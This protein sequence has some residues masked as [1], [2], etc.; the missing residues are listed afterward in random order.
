[1]DFDSTGEVADTGVVFLP[2]IKDVAE[3]NQQ[4][5]TQERIG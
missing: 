5:V 4:T 2:G 3:A 1:V